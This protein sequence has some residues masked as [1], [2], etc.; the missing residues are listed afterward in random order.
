MIIFN[1]DQKSEDYDNLKDVFRPSHADYT[2][3]K[4]YGLSTFFGLLYRDPSVWNCGWKRR[5]CHMTESGR[6]ATAP[7]EK[8]SEG[9]CTQVLH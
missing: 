3:L 2:Y 4:K 6:G 1:E 5:D 8:C 7:M 9:D